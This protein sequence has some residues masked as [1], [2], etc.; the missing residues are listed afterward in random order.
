MPAHNKRLA[1]IGE[2]MLELYQHDNDL[3]HLGF[4]GDVYN[5]AA[6]FAHCAEDIA[7][8]DLISAVGNDIYSQRLLKAVNEKSVGTSQVRTLDNRMPGLYLVE[9]DDTGERAFHYY[10]SEA[11]ARHM[12]DGPEGDTLLKK[13]Y[14]YDS[15][16][17]S[18]ITLAILED[19]SR[20]KFIEALADLHKHD[21]MICF[22]SNYRPK[23]WESHEQAQHCYDQIMPFIDIALPSLADD[24]VLYGGSTLDACADRFLNAGCHKVIITH[25][26]NDYMIATKEQRQL[27]PVAA[28]NAVDTTGAGDSFN[29]AFLAAILQ[30]EDD[31]AAANKAAALSAKVVQAK[32]AIII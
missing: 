6:Y 23:L 15:V 22:D 14:E 20:G 1:C 9:N 21:V 2:C 3:F 17:F 28:V 29:A 26:E 11:A 12:F 31:E 5:M 13:L 4:A 25:G 10:R 32:G 24:H 16:Y 18:G 7:S 27:Y 30:G 8:V 19:E